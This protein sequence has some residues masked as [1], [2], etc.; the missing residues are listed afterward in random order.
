MVILHWL[1]LKTMLTLITTTKHHTLSHHHGKFSCKPINNHLNLT[2]HMKSQITYN[3]PYYKSFIWINNLNLTVLLS[4]QSITSHIG[5]S[6]TNVPHC[7]LLSP[8]SYQ[9]FFP[10]WNFQN[11]YKK[12]KKRKKKTSLLCITCRNLCTTGTL[13]AQFQ[14]RNYKFKKKK[15][16]KVIQKISIL[17]TIMIKE[18]SQYML[19]WWRALISIH[20]LQ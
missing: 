13:Q 14:R 1:W 4:K 20:A 7:C 2:V 17:E 18:N 10:H 15:I 3:S 11:F 19:S 12:E 5:I 6:H 9:I 8:N 16:C